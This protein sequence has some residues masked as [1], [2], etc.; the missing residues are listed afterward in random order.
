MYRAQLLFE[1]QGFD[2]IPYKVDY[3]SEKDKEITIINFI[4]SIEYL[5]IT[6]TE[7]IGRIFYLVKN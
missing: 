7:I 6:E 4:P 5:K 2:V 1:K 3:T